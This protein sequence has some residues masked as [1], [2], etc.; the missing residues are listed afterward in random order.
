MNKNIVI[1][2]AGDDWEKEIPITNEGTRL[3]I[4]DWMRRAERANI[5]LYRASVKW[6]DLE[7]N[8]FTKGWTFSDGTWRKVQSEISADLIYDK[9]LSKYDYSLL[10]F[11]L[12]IAQKTRLFN[13]PLFRAT[14]NS[15]LSQYAMFGE[16]MPLTRIA[17]NKN[18]LELAISQNKTD[19]IVIKP[20]YGSGGFGIFIGEISNAFSG[21]YTYPVLVQEFITSEKGIPGFSPKDEVSDIRLVYQGGKMAYALSRIAAAGSL[22]TNL[23][24][25]ATGK[26]IPKEKIPECMKEMIKV[27]NNKISVFPNAQYSLDFIFDN[28]GRPYFIE[29]NTCPGIDLVTFLGDEK[30]KQENFETIS[31]LLK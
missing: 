6:Y 22:F 10:D 29:M 30:T 21:E 14:F 26:M 25:G 20:L 12:K 2:Y 5:G 8:I 3:A 15:K 19:K 16:F 9:V 28:D 11:K 24:Q 13:D 7:K 23:H 17:N 18:E 31:E 27:I 1:M 4:Q